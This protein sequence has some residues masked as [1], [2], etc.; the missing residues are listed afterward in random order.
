M[1]DFKIGIRKFTENSGELLNEARTSL[2]LHVLYNN[3]RDVNMT[4]AS[5]R[6]PDVKKKE[7]RTRK[8]QILMILYLPFGSF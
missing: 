8:L 5:A 6:R 2:L 1:P 4:Q 7:H 3:S